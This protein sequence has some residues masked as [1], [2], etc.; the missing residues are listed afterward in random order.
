MEGSVRLM[1]AE[2]NE[3]EQLIATGL[4]TLANYK[5]NEIKSLC[6]TLASLIDE[7]PDR[8]GYTNS[9]DYIYQD[10]PPD[11]KLGNLLEWLRIKAKSNNDQ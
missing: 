8:H 5:N 10:D 11:Q 2:L 9:E 1:K 7:E 3:E 6:K 4:F